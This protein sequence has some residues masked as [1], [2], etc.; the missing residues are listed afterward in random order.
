MSMYSIAKIVELPATF[1]ELRHAATHEPLPSLSKL[2]L[3][4]QKALT[5]I[6]GYFWGK[7]SDD[8]LNSESCFTYVQ[9]LLREKDSK[10]DTDL[11]LKKSRW[12][13]KE[14]LATLLDLSENAQEPEV[15][16]GSLKIYDSLLNENETLDTDG[17]GKN[18]ETEAK[19]ME[20]IMAE[21]AKMD[22]DLE[23]STSNKALE[24]PIQLISAA[25][26]GRK[27]WARWEGPW[28]PAPIGTIIE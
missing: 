12:S 5:W 23:E 27:G 17:S 6:W 14:V 13:R 8:T 24:E 20:E 9:R 10:E 7:L 16:L 28:K 25:H 18:G 26:D 11:D 15:L 3:A 19:S 2:R 1:V 21:V 22:E 4:S